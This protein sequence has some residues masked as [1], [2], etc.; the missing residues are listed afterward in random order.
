MSPGES[1]LS[2][3]RWVG[4]IVKEFIQLR[5]DRLT[6]GMIIGIPVLQLL[7]FGYAINADPKNLPTAVYSADASPF[8]RSLVAGMRNSGYDHSEPLM[9]NRAAGYEH[10]KD[11]FVNAE[12]LDMS[13][14]YAAGSLYST[15]EDLYLWDQALYTEKLLSNELKA[16]LWTPFLA[17]Y[18]YGW[19]VAKIAEGKAGAGWG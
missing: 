14:P 5:R 1:G 12:Y 16:K 9:E 3:S 19:G 10:G 7:L 15:A 8:A 6:F 18:A 13:I 2:W 11:G 17:G 4:I